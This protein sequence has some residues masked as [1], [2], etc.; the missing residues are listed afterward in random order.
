MV[1]A[2]ASSISPRLHDALRIWNV[3]STT[4]RAMSRPAPS[5]PSRA[6]A[7]MVASVAVT[8]LLALPRNPRPSNAAVT[9]SPGLSLGT[10]HSVAPA[11]AATGR[12][13]Q[14]YESASPADVTQLLLALRTTPSPSSA[15]VPS[16]AQNWLRDPVSEK[17]SVDRC[18][19]RRSPGAPRRGR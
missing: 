9:D 16:G 15:A 19:R 8:G 4:P 14:T 18:V 2:I 6:V 12:L 7:G 11:S 13:V 10:S 5:S 17:A 3:G 1:R